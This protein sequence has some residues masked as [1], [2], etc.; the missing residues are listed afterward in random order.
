MYIHIICVYINRGNGVFARVSC[1][2]IPQPSAE[3]RGAV[4]RHVHF[5]QS[6]DSR[7]SSR[8]MRILRYRRCEFQRVRFVVVWIAARILQRTWIFVSNV[9]RCYAHIR[10]AMW[11]L[12]YGYK[13]QPIA[14]R[15]SLLCWLYSNCVWVYFKTGRS[16]GFGMV[17][18]FVLCWDFWMEF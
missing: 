1:R 6:S 12:S 16:N 8:I 9:A 7:M 14:V 15:L 2:R 11:P 3:L 18:S 17:G 13:I 5:R 4:V 10:Y